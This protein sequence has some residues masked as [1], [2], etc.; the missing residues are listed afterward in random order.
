[1]FSQKTR[2]S[3]VA[4]AWSNLSAYISYMASSPPICLKQLDIIQYQI[5]SVGRSNIGY[6][7]ICETK[8]LVANTDTY[9][10]MGTS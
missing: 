8:E 7:D 9:R 4:Y 3:F 10:H 6:F 5:R 2:A 1:M